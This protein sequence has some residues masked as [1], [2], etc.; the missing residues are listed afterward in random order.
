MLIFLDDRT[1]LEIKLSMNNVP[2]IVIRITE[3]SSNIRVYATD[4]I[5]SPNKKD[6]ILYKMT[7]SHVQI[8]NKQLKNS[9]F[10]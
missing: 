5:L 10:L 2:V 1:V 8:V 7:N 3:I 9:P 6:K 4:G